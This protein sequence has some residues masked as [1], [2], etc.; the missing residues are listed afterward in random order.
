M[1]IYQYLKAY[2][3]ELAQGKKREIVDKKE[4]DPISWALF[5]HIL[6]WAVSSGNVFVWVYSL[7]QW[8]LMARSVNI[9][10]LG[11]HNFQMGDDSI[12]CTYNYS[13]TDQAGDFVTAKNIYVNTGVWFAA[14]CA[15]YC[16]AD[17]QIYNFKDL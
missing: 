5:V 7:L 14:C 17:L 16:N 3:K 12:R 6:T 1:Q 11:F 4:T 2:K 8:N 13:K 9:D 10:P 15:T